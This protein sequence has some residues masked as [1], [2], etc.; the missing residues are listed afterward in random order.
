MVTK[1][2]LFTLEDFTY[3]VSTKKYTV[4]FANSRL[5]DL[6]QIVFDNFHYVNST[7]YTHIVL[8][9]SNLVDTIK[10]HQSYSGKNHNSKSTCLF[11][12]SETHDK[13]RFFLNSPRRFS[14]DR[15]IHKI[16]IWFTDSNNLLTFK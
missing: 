8:C 7:C 10:D 9:H 11:S 15:G 14:V 3:D 6:K 4:Q 2:Y 1:T 13:G 16:E 12:L 5:Q